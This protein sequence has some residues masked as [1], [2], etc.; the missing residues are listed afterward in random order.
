MGSGSGSGLVLPTTPPKEIDSTEILARTDTVPEAYIKHVLIGWKDLAAAYRGHMDPRAAAR[1][2]ATAAKLAQEILAKLKANPE[3]LDT[4]SK[5]TSEDPGSKSGDPYTVTATSHFVP[6]FLKLALRLKE[7]EAG[8]VRTDFG[9]HVM[10]RIPKPP[11]DPLESADI[12]ARTPDAAKTPI[13]IQHILI[14][15]KEKP[16]AGDPRA[17]ER[18]KADADKLAKD[19][20]GKLKAGGDMAKLMKEH[21]EDPDTKETG[22]SYPVTADM[23]LPDPMKNLALRLKLNEAGLVMTP[24]GWFIMKRVPP[25]PPDSLE[26][27]DILKREPPEAKVKVKH[28]LLGWKEVHGKDP[29]GA[30]RDRAA[31]E[32]LVKETVAKL[33]KGDKIEA[34]MK[35]ISEDPGSAASGE[36]YDVTPTTQFVPSFKSLALRLKVKEV[37]VVKSDYGIHIMQRTE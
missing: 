3:S 28:I 35:E 10:M 26:S 27:A 22:K 18:T 20:L 17:K 32:K 6:P 30:A 23:G 19:V 1:D 31:L 14:G 2:N 33:K 37:G 34:L 5:E 11:P 25:P 7:K 24:F 36:G 16:G 4:L 13:I 12:L 21:S 8:I 15:W 29:R 9:Y